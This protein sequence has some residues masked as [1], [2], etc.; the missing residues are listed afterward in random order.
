MKFRWMEFESSIV[1]YLAGKESVSL[2]AWNGGEE[3]PSRTSHFCLF[4]G[5]PW[6]KF[7]LKNEG[8]RCVELKRARN[9]SLKIDGCATETS[10]MILH[11]HLV[12]D[13]ER[14]VEWYTR[15][16]QHLSSEEEFDYNVSETRSL[17]LQLIRKQTKVSCAS[18]EEERPY[19]MWFGDVEETSKREASMGDGLLLETHGGKDPFVAK[20]SV[21]ET[22]IC[23]A[24]SKILMGLLLTWE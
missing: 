12:G 18:S 19:C 23:L 4:P 2:V 5:G 24:G 14:T 10:Y 20:R 16:M 13:V 1:K 17:R 21:Q 22:W 8:Y 7:S 3:W 9:I 15:K 11:S 6:H